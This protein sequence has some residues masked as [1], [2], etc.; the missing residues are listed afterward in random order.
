MFWYLHLG[1]DVGHATP[2]YYRID[3]LSI[4]RA[5]LLSLCVVAHWLFI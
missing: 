1:N 5:L 4:V 2:L 3:H